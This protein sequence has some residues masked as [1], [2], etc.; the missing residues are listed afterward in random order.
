MRWLNAADPAVRAAV[1]SGVYGKTPH[2]PHH[3]PVPTDRT[4]IDVIA[5][6]LD[7]ASDSLTT[8]TA[9]AIH[10]ALQMVE[11][12]VCYPQTLALT[13]SLGPVQ[14]DVTLWAMQDDGT[15]L[16]EVEAAQVFGGS[17]RFVHRGERANYG[18]VGQPMYYADQVVDLRWA[19][20][21]AMGCGCPP[22]PRLRLIYDA[23]S[24]ISA[25]ARAAVLAL[26][27]ELYLQAEPCDECGEC[28]LP[29]RTTSVQ[30]E[31]ISFTLADPAD[32]SNPRSGTGLPEVDLWVQQV[33]PYRASRV[34]RVYD[35]TRPPPVVQ[36]IISATPVFPAVPG[37]K[38][39]ATATVV[40]QGVVA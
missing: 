35:A 22:N 15:P 12:F 37:G 28:R 3:A 40:A 19:W 16:V 17:V 20:I 9:G 21:R 5:A 14:P 7:V 8:L 39:G 38:T 25:S 13:P 1:V 26:A 11:D 2:S 10:P 4:E 18:P 27:H 31:G 24:T 33:N 32:P 30:R 23:G 6:A 36:S 34:P 29:L